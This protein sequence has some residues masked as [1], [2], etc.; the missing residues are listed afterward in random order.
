[1]Q[2]GRALTKNFPQSTTKYA[3]VINISPTS[4]EVV[5]AMADLK[6]D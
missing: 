2:A 4:S 1:M 6:P 3:Y 5:H